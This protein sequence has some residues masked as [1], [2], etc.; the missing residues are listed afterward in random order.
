[1]STREKPLMLK[2]ADDDARRNALR[3][4][5]TLNCSEAAVSFRAKGLHRRHWNQEIRCELIGLFFLPVAAVLFFDEKSA[6]AMQ[7]NMSG[8]MEKGEPEMVVG[9]V[10][11]TELD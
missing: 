1:M 2:S 7:Q 10:P 11:Q 6:L 8:F 9:F 5:K 4:G 3:A